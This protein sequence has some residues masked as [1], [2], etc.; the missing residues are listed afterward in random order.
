MHL[1]GRV[2]RISPPRLRAAATSGGSVKAG[3]VDL[4]AE[5]CG[6]TQRHA[7]ADAVLLIDR[8]RRPAPMLKPIPSAAAL[9]LLRTAWPIIELH[10]RRRH[11]QVI[12]ALAQQCALFEC[13]LSR[14]TDDLLIMIDSIQQSIR[15]RGR[16]A[17]LE[18]TVNPALRHRVSA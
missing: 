5:H 2:E 8:V 18:V 6:I 1:P 3:W 13:Q 4:A 15:S 12:T 17:R 16:N 10:P 7:F 14:S 11:G 9:P